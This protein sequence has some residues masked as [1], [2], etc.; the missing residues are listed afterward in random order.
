[1]LVL[2]HKPLGNIMNKKI[3]ISG[4][5]LAALFVAA[6]FFWSSPVADKPEAV[7]LKP[8]W[9]AQQVRDWY[10]KKSI[11]LPEAALENITDEMVQEY[12]AVSQPT[13]DLPTQQATV[14]HKLNDRL[15]VLSPA[16]DEAQ[17]DQ[18]AKRYKL[19]Y[20]VCHLNSQT[21]NLL[22]GEYR[23]DFQTVLNDLGVQQQCEKSVCGYAVGQGALLELAGDYGLQGGDN[24]LAINGVAVADMGGFEAFQS[25]LLSRQQGVQ[26]QIQREGLVQD[27]EPV[28]CQR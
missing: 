25:S 24:I 15:T 4:L 26:L 22:K 18:D 21:L 28:E 19:E 14:E 16:V 27:L 5:L 1:V 8:E 11:N 6:A 17:M 2:L 23:D 20:A 13:A 9:T 12:I 3:L 10:R 7:L